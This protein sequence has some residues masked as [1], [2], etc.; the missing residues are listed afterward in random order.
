[1]L[2]F[3]KVNGKG[4]RQLFRYRRMAWGKECWHAV[5]FCLLGFRCSHTPSP[6]RYTANSLH[7]VADSTHCSAVDFW[8]SLAKNE[9]HI[10]ARSFQKVRDTAVTKTYLTAARIKSIEQFKAI[11][12]RHTDD[13]LNA[14]Q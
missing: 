14:L 5:T 11:K 10:S 1:M 7:L 8:K 6:E 3:Q 2:N 13:W 4:F 12:S 9:E